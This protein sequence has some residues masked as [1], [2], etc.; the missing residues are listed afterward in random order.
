MMYLSKLGSPF[1]VLSIRVPYYTPNVVLLNFRVL[2]R[3]VPYYTPNVVPTVQSVTG[4]ESYKGA[5]VFW[6]P[7]KGP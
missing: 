4:N 3:R 2:F 1:R 6:G 5:V 7:E